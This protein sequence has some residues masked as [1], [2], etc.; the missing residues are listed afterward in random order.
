MGQRD[1]SLRGFHK[2]ADHWSYGVSALILGRPDPMWSGI[3]A[4]AGFGA[5]AII[6][7]SA[8]RSGAR[9]AGATFDELYEAEWSRALGLSYWFAIGLYPLV[10]V[11]LVL[12][13]IEHPVAFAAMGTLT[14]SAPLLLYCLI[15]ARG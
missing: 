6:W 10:S 5:G 2:T 9:V 3:P 7:T 11:F 1:E 8:L 14:G 15:S 12:D 4:I 13:M